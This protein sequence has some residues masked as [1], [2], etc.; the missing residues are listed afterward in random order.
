MSNCQTFG[1]GLDDLGNRSFFP[2]I[3]ESAIHNSPRSADACRK[4]SGPLVVRA[5][6]FMSV[7][8][9]VFLVDDDAQM[10]Q[11]LTWLLERNGYDVVA[12]ASPSEA[13]ANYDVS[14]P[15]CL[16]LDIQLPEANGIELYEQLRQRGR[17]H[18]FI[19]IT[20]YGRVPLAVE[21]MRLGAVDF[22]EKPFQSEQ[23]LIRIGEAVAKDRETRRTDVETNDLLK[24]LNVLG[25]REWQV[26]ALVAAGKSSREIG[27]TLSIK[28]RT[29][30][31]HRHNILTKLKADSSGE[32]AALFTKAKALKDQ[33]LINF[34]E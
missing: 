21:A 14:R 27:E 31:V 34:P 18:P 6:E 8:P 12:S 2:A 26:A 19:V 1:R 5:S 30:E 11:S 20:A 33:G 32:V 16:L 17:V 29:V 7:R 13:L 3:A 23:L 10:R 24:R 22:I 28:L 4:I 9:T 25:R 15:G